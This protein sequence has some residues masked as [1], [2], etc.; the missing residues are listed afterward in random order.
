MSLWVALGVIVYFLPALVAAGR[1][2]PWWAR[3]GV[4]EY[5]IGCLIFGW[6]VVGWMQLLHDAWTTDG[7]A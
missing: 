1:L 5:V 3:Y 4:I 6:T 7:S 2:R